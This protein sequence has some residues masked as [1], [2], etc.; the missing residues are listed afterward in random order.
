MHS[1]NKL[2]KIGSNYQTM[3]PKC[4]NNLEDIYQKRK[5]LSEKNKD[6]STIPQDGNYPKSNFYN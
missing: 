2:V 1:S 3:I 4:K 6:I 5:T